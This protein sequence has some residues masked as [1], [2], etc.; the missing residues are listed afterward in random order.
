M[1]ILIL[2][3]SYKGTLSSTEVIDVL[4]GILHEELPDA[5]VYSFPFSDGGENALDCY[6][7]VLKE[8]REIR[9]EAFSPD[10]RRKQEVSYL[11]YKDR[12][13]VESAKAIGLMQVEEKNPF[14]TSSY[15][16]GEVL[17][18]ILDC[19]ISSFILTLGG[20]CTNDGG[21]G[22]L[23]ALGVRFM[24]IHG[25]PF[26]PTGG[27]LGDIAEIE[28]SHLDRRLKNCHFFLLSDC[29]NPLLGENGASHVFSKQKGA[30]KKEERDLLEKN[31]SY[32]CS[33]LE[34]KTS[35]KTRNLPGMGA[36]GG[37][38]FGISQFF[39]FTL[40]SG[41]EEI[42]SLY[43]IDSLLD[44]VDLLITGEGRTDSSSLDG[45]CISVL[46]SHAKKKKKKV[47]LVS[48]YIEPEVIP[49]LSEIGITDCLSV[50]KDENTD[51][52]L[53]QKHARENLR[54]AFRNYLKEGKKRCFI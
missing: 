27:S 15:P 14:L 29:T 43:Q 35:K 21:S 24:D 18:S 42:L 10:L 38:P 34:K 11:I 6:K 44:E 12:A 1:K 26:V 19:G 51:F 30:D 40:S 16:L 28:T 7:A 47:L 32:Y 37:L 17:L 20:T 50:E 5:K 54:K 31:M 22:M 2:P 3:D 25:H 39:S 41:A 9:M 13:I 53:I 45:K 23:S 33:L 46:A 4:Q 52:S 8:A 49:S 48:G 36:A